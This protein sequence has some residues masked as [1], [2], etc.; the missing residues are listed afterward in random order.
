MA[1][2]SDRYGSAIRPTPCAPFQGITWG[3]NR[4][5]WQLHNSPLG[6]WPIQQ[7]TVMHESG[8]HPRRKNYLPA[9]K[10]RQQSMSERCRESA[11]LQVG[12]RVADCLAPL[13]HNSCQANLARYPIIAGYE[14][15]APIAPEI[16]SR[17]TRFSVRRQRHRQHHAPDVIRT[18]RAIGCRQPLDQPSRPTESRERQANPPRVGA[19][20]GAL[21]RGDSRRSAQ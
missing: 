17:S 9:K 15:P 4:E 1:H 2:R 18:V 12:V 3:H 13:P 11:S 19:L 6:C 8:Q 21:Y 16:S 20:P 14:C 10:T 7:R 5:T